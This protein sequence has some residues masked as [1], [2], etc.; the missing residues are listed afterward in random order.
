MTDGV[1]QLISQQ[2]DFLLLAIIV[3]QLGESFVGECV[4]S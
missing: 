3:C 4:I 2:I 1:H